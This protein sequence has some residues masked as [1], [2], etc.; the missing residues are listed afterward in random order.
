MRIIYAVPNAAPSDGG[1]V[2][3]EPGTQITLGSLSLA[4]GDND[5]SV[6]EDDLVELGIE[7]DADYDYAAGLID[8]TI[9]GAE[10]GASYNLVVPLAISIPANSEYRKYFNERYRLAGISTVTATGMA[11]VTAIASASGC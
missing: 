2:E 8:F 9:S 3:T 4:N 1:V 7:P 10:P 11:P 5:I 6:A